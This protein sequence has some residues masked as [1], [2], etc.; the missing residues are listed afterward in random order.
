MLDSYLEKPYQNILHGKILKLNTYVYPTIWH[1]AWLI[2][3]KGEDFQNL[4]NKISK[5]FQYIKGTE[6]MEQVS[7][8]VDEG[9]LNLINLRERIET[10]KAKQILD[11]ELQ[12]PESDN[13]IYQVGVKQHKIYSKQFPGPKSLTPHSK[14]RHTVTMLEQNILVIRNFKTRK[15]KFTTK[16]LQSILF[17]KQKRHYYKENLQAVEQ[18]LKSCNY[19]IVHNLGP[20]RSNMPCPL[21]KKD[22]DCSQHLL[23]SCKVTNK[24]RSL[25]KEWLNIFNIEFNNANIVEMK[26]VKTGIINHIISYYKFNCLSHKM[27][28][29]KENISDDRIAA[30][31]DKDVPFYVENIPSFIKI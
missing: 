30:K 7:K 3:T 4:L 14:L 15:K 16:D 21:C 17:P 6:I 27:L 9:G 29:W 5:F 24:A 2:D 20:F 13:I 31:F 18:K 28:A 19:L 11:S 12:I 23:F 26:D 25:A 22:N 8:N 1:R 10:I